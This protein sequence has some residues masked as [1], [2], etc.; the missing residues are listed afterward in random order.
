MA[1][2]QYIRGEALRRVLVARGIECSPEEASLL[3]SLLLDLT[4]AGVLQPGLASD[5]LHCTSPLSDTDAEGCPQAAALVA[6]DACGQADSDKDPIVYNMGSSI[7][8]DAK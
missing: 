3:T 6:A 7:H 4:V 1:H 5:S 2:E 8:G